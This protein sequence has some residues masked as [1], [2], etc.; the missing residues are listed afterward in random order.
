[1]EVSHIDETL[2]FVRWK[3]DDESVAPK[4]AEFNVAVTDI[5][6]EKQ[7]EGASVTGKL[8]TVLN[9]V[10]AGKAYK[11][12]VSVKVGEVQKDSEAVTVTTITGECRPAERTIELD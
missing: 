5:Q 8:Y 11:I 1:M 7:V 2:L 6:A 10:E 3:W 12:V 9:K 4:D